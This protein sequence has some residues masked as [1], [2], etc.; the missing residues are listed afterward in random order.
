M[1]KKTRVKV[2]VDIPDVDITGKV[3]AIGAFLEQDTLYCSVTFALIGGNAQ[4]YQF[5][6]NTPFMA[7]LW[8]LS[9]CAFEQG[10]TI[11]VNTQP[12]VAPQIYLSKN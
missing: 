11:V 5:S 9:K 12:N 8:D 10:A 7:A 3:T 6:T 4:T 2:L 1:N